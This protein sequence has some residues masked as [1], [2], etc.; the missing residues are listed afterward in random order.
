MKSTPWLDFR[1]C[2]EAE[3]LQRTGLI[4]LVVGTWLTLFNLG[5]L[6]LLGDVDSWLFLKIFLNYITP[7]IVAN[8]GL[9]SRQDA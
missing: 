5:D 9:L 6:I 2:L 1:V 4:S 7:F 3:H 8:A